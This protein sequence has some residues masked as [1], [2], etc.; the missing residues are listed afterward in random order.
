[1]GSTLAR[2]ARETP[3]AARR[4]LVDTA[5]ILRALGARLRARP[6]TTI[7]TCARG[8]SDHAALYGK[9]L[10]ETAL[11]RVVASVGPS[12]AS[13][14]R[15]PLALEGAL[16][17]AVSQSGRSPDLVELAR[18]AGTS[19]ALVVGFLND[20]SSPLA[21][22]CD[23]V[24]PLAAGPEHAVA[25]TKSCLLA[26]LAFL[27]LVAEWTAEPEIRDAVTRAPDALAAA[28]DRD[29]SEGLAPLATAHHAY[30]LGRGL[31]LGAAME[32][33]LKL[34]EACA[35]HAEGF[36][37]A[38]VLHGPLALVGA[39]FPI[40]ALAQADETLG[41]TRETLARLVGL[42]AD[43]RTT[44]DVPGAVQLPTVS[45]VP[46]VLDPLCHL[47]SCYLALTALARARCVDPDRPRHL[48]KVT[49]T[50]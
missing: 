48:A 9:Y 41:P 33:A 6:P 28:C 36:S 1:M 39:G 34:K 49:E 21:N 15:A 30:V 4:Q 46:A 17:V 20:A 38:E 13:T 2:E 19:G 44:I 22:E 40:V 35:L 29:W 47:Q 11:G 24:V 16:V 5:S 14:Y 25:A 26:K 27:Q 45:G 50:R 8:S 7:I 37:T 23:V 31:G 32:L 43:V 10:I 18:S 3:E 42:G 12:V